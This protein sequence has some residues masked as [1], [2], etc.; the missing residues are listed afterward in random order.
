MVCAVRGHFL[1]AIWLELTICLLMKLL[2]LALLAFF[3][4]LWLARVIVVVF[5]KFKPISAKSSFAAQASW[6]D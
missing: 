5:S 2:V 6:G 4:L 1:V 3:I